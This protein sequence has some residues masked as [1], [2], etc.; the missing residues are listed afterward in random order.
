MSYP[1]ATIAC[2]F[3]T[4]AR[5]IAETPGLLRRWK[6]LQL[7]S[8]RRLGVTVKKLA[9]DTGVK[10]RTIRRDLNLLKDFGLPLKEL[11]GTNGKKLR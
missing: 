2:D 6:I 9:E 10:L 1:A 3:K 5:G 11:S 7:L 4:K 8:A